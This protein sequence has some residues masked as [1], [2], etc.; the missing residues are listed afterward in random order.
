[1]FS[2]RKRTRIQDVP[3]TLRVAAR[4]DVGKVRERNED[5]FVVA[6]LDRNV[7][8][9]VPARLDAG[10]AGVLLAVADGMG[11]AEAGDVASA[12]ALDDLRRIV[13]SPPA[14]VP[15]STLLEQAF[16]HAHRA[17]RDAS[18]GQPEKR[19]MGT[20]LTAVHVQGGEAYV[21]HVGDS[22][23]YLVRA[24]RIAPITHD[25][26]VVQQLVDS[27]LLAPEDIDASPFRS[28]ILQAVGH[29]PD[30]DVAVSR[31]E[32]RSRDCIVLCSDGLTN[33]VSDAELLGTVLTSMSL[34]VAAQRLVDLANQ[35]GG[36]DNITVVL[37]GVGGEL[38]PPE[39]A[40][41]QSIEVVKAFVARL[42]S[43]H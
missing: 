30:L 10:H 7:T 20:T 13:A 12:I 24:G 14:N 32:L 40:A 16:H 34:D 2:P 15:R 22:R 25:Q 27:G 38:P 31:V 6:D 42:P 1:M 41:E 37:A 33:A 29:Q 26:T 17:I 11:G 36:K 8:P 43:H 18:E 5:G 4:T 3:T 9:A 19:R 35:R 23:A 21:A 28:V 39:I